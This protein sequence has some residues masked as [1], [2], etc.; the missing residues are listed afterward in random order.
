MATRFLMKGDD[1]QNR[2]F[3]Y[4]RAFSY[5]AFVFVGPISILFVDPPDNYL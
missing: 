2:K 5:T 3:Y 4:F 1:Q